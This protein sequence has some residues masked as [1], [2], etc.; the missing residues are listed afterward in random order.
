M[1][2][3]T[4]C[5]P[6]AATAICVAIPGTGAERSPQPHQRLAR[7]HLPNLMSTELLPLPS[8]RPVTHQASVSTSKAATH[9]HTAICR[10]TDTVW[11]LTDRLPSPGAK[12]KCAVEAAI[13]PDGSIA[14]A[15]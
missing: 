4:A 8:S 3:E 14:L 2:S 7:G 15:F 11:F 1:A 12:S 6:A 9:K 10:V 5:G 13:G